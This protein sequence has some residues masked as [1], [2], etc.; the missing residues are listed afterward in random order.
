[1]DERQKN[2]LTFCSFFLL[3]LFTRIWLGL[4]KITVWRQHGDKNSTRAVGLSGAH[5]RRSDISCTGS[6]ANGLALCFLP[7]APLPCRILPHACSA[8]APRYAPRLLRAASAVAFARACAAGLLRVNSALCLRFIFCF[9]RYGNEA[10]IASGSIVTASTTDRLEGINVGSLAM[11]LAPSLCA[12]RHA[13]QYSGD[14]LFF[15][16]KNG[17]ATTADMMTVAAA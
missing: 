13:H 9:Q 4:V 2:A 14:V 10:D 6:A 17:A 7:A 16:L 1:V 12:P 3:P 11:A 8:C 5:Q 15:W